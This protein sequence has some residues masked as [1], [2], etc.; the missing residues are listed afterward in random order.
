LTEEIGEYMLGRS[1][2]KGERGR[3]SGRRAAEGQGSR[4]AGCRGEQA[5]VE[6][7]RGD[8]PLIAEAAIVPLLKEGVSGH[9][10]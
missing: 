9:R 7:G 10:M 4:G 5:I 8:L 3:R 6:S 1:G 2:A